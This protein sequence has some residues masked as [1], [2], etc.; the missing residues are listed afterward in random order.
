MSTFTIPP[1][2]LGSWFANRPEAPARQL[3]VGA[4][5][6]LQEGEV[7]SWYTQ[8][9][10]TAAE[11][12]AG[13]RAAPALRRVSLRSTAL[14][15]EV[16]EALAGLPSLE[17]LALEKVPLTPALA[18]VLASSPRLRELE[19]RGTPAPDDALA[20]LARAALRT[21]SIEGPGEGFTDASVAR[22]ARCASLTFL[23]V[24]LAPSV[25]GSALASLKMLPELHTL[26]L[27]W[28]GAL[29]AK[30][31][32]SGLAAHPSLRQLWLEHLA[33]VGDEACAVAASIPA[34]TSLQLAGCKRVTDAGLAL[35]HAHPALAHVALPSSKHAKKVTTAGLEAL[36]TARPGC[37]IYR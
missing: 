27:A 34:L 4:P 25:T 14:D 30:K 21:L 24:S 26:A 29:D 12:L 22:L 11:V 7:L 8:E 31:H 9:G 2:A 3:T 17:G 16:V 5:A 1:Q 37:N 19:L 13:L 32:L 6:Q 23:R 15:A 36:K 33:T 28:L 35:L 20:H 10:L 18:E